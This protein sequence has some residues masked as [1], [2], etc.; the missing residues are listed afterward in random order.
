MV[1]MDVEARGGGLQQHLDVVQGQSV[2]LP[3]LER[4]IRLA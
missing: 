3:H 1:V 4:Q 2:T